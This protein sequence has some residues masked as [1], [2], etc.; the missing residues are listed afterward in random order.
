MCMIHG[1][2]GKDSPLKN[3]IVSLVDRDYYYS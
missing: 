3:G 1:D 2:I